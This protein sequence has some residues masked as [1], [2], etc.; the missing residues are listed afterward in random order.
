MFSN[1]NKNVT[2]DKNMRID[3]ATQTNVGFYYKV[4]IAASRLKMPDQEIKNAYSGPEKV[5]E[6]FE[7]N[8][9]K[10]SIGSFKHYKDAHIFLD[11]ISVKGAFVIAYY[12]GKRIKITTEMATP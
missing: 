6:T 7:E 12:N 8:R 5:I 2:L 11:S 4:Q 9:F 1:I 10:Y 3:P